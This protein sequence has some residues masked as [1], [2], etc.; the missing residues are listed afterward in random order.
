[1]AGLTSAGFDWIRRTGSPSGHPDHRAG[2]G[3]G[4]AGAPIFTDK[5]MEMRQGFWRP[6]IWPSASA[7]EN[8]TRG[9]FAGDGHWLD[10]RLKTVA[11]VVRAS[12]NLDFYGI[13]ATVL[14]DNP[15]RYNL[16]PRPASV[17]GPLSSRR[18]AGPGRT[19]LCPRQHHGR[20]DHLP[21]RAY[22]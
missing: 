2:G 10:D 4:A 11:G 14:Q 17:P 3:C 8:G 16:K 19:G 12:V 21:I 13:G 9:A 22:P 6:N 18:S 1:M 5:Q 20:P 7:T 15:R